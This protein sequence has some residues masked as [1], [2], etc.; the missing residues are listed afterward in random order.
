MDSQAGS[1]WREVSIEAVAIPGLFSVPA[2]ERVSELAILIFTWYNQAH[3]HVGLGLMTPDQV[4]YGQAD[5]IHAA[6]QSTLNERLRSPSRTLRQT[7]TQTA[8]QA[9][10]RLDQPAADQSWP[11]ENMRQNRLASS[12]QPKQRGKVG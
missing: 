10:R 4:H 9:N 3:H 12:R 7:T 2:R 11:D 6:R 8:R 1:P 5:E